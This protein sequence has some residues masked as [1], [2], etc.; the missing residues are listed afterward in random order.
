MNMKMKK[1]LCL[2][3]LL[4]LGLGAMT[5]QARA[6]STGTAEVDFLVTYNGQLCVAVDGNAYSTYS[7]TGQVFSNGFVVP[8]GS[9]TVKSADLAGADCGL[10]ER[11]E[12]DVSTI[13]T[14]SWGLYSATNSASVNSAA[15]C[16]NNC[17]GVNQYGFQALFVSSNTGTGAYGAANACPSISS[18]TWD[19][20]VDSVPS[21]PGF[22]DQFGAP[23]FGVF[24]KT[25]YSS[26]N[27]VSGTSG[28]PD[29]DVGAGVTPPGN[30]GDMYPL[31]VSGQPA[32]V[33]R[34]G[35][36]V[37]VTMPASV[38]GAGTGAQTIQLEITAIG[39]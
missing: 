2:G 28:W 32:G 5:Q 23:G 15:A 16:V 19:M 14:S 10:I 6:A 36:C 33:G 26:P 12:L 20:Y 24:L 38:S 30:S 8:G 37:R 13:G 27:T 31:D 11:W 1:F 4:V 17:P 35:L 9:I 3:A 34:R 39:A 22:A 7:L 18:S 29:S 21:H 25:Q